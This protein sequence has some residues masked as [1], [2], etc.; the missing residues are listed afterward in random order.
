MVKLAV[1]A[2]AQ[3][4]SAVCPSAQVKRSESCTKYILQNKR[5]GQD[6]KEQGKS[7]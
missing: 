1:V 4:P 7:V 6:W 2:L 5:S 3:D